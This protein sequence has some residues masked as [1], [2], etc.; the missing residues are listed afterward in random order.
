MQEEAKVS[1]THIQRERQEIE[2]NT[3][4]ILYYYYCCCCF[5][6]GQCHF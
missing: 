2:T 6:K 4:T 5:Q 1:L 3:K